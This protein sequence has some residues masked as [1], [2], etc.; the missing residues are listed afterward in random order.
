MKSSRSKRI[1]CIKVLLGLDRTEHLQEVPSLSNG[2]G[3]EV[4]LGDEIV[5][6]TTK[7]RYFSR[8]GIVFGALP[9]QV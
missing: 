2:L 7:F 4:V 9:L 3:Y 1:G 6:G 5:V 8:R